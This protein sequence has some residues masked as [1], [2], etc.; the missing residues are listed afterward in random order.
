MTAILLS[1]ILDDL[2][3]AEEGLHR[4]ER[5]YW[6][7]STDFYELYSQGLLDDGSNSEDFA[8]W[9]GH[10]KL[11]LKRQ[12]ALERLSKQRVQQLQGKA[13]DRPIQLAPQEPM[14][15]L[16]DGELLDYSYTVIR[17]NEK[18]RWYDPQPHPENPDLAATFP[19]HRHEPPDIKHNRRPAPGISFTEPNLPT[20]IADCLAL[21]AE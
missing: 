11:R 12:A 2:R 20:L 16:S 3:A 17:S 9:S 4:F 15:E 1:E 8:E 13:K 14:L 6:I 5:R 19:H 10:Y 21:G 18:I 7:S